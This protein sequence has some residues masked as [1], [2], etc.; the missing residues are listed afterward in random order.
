MPKWYGGYILNDN[1]SPTE[2]WK[3]QWGRVIRWFELVTQIK[4]KNEIPGADLE[5]RDLDMVIAFFQNCCHLR[6]WL[7]VSRPDLHDKLDNFFKQN[8][9]MKGCRDI[10]NGF[11][12]K[13]LTRP[14]LDADFN[15]A[16][17]YDYLEKMGS[18]THKN[19]VKYNI[20]FAYG[21]DIRNYDLF[22]YA[23]QCFALWK[24]FLSAEQLL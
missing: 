22:D 13:K 24:G 21:D 6:D 7:E 4:A 8:F 12:H 15:I 17:E 19:P 23:R 11:K 10:C 3:F 18:G 5:A 1:E 2:E 16:R 14:S 9:E 20:A